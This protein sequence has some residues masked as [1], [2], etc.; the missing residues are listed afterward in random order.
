MT[1]NL[2]ASRSNT[3]KQCIGKIN[4]TPNIGTNYMRIFYVLERNRGFENY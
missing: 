4:I 3:N 1:R 2:V